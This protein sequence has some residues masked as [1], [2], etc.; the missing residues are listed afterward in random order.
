[1]VIAAVIVLVAG[2]VGTALWLM[3]GTGDQLLRAVPGDADAAVT[4]YLDPSASQKMQLV[5]MLSRFPALG[6]EQAVLDRWNGVLDDALEQAGLTHEDLDWVGSQI[7]AWGDFAGGEPRGGVLLHVDDRAAAEDAMRRLQEDATDGG[8]TVTQRDHEGTEVTVFDGEGAWAIEDDVLF[9]GSD[10]IAVTHAL[11]AMA[12][13]S[14]ALEDAAAFTTATDALPQDRLALFYADVEGLTD[15]IQEMVGSSTPAMPTQSAIQFGVSVSAEAEGLA[16][17]F[18]TV[19]DPTQLDPEVRDAMDADQTNGTLEAVPADAVVVVGATHVDLTIEQALEALPPEAG[20]VQQT[21]EDAGVLGP[22]GL[23]ENLRGDLSL[24]MVPATDLPV[25]GVLA[26]GVDDEA[27]FASFVQD[28]LEAAGLPPEFRD[29]PTEDHGG[30]AVH[31]APRDL[32]APVAWAVTDGTALVG[33]TEGVVGAAEALASGDSIAG[34][35]RYAEAVDLVDA[36]DSLFYADVEG[37]LS[38]VRS[39]MPPD[40]LAEFEDTVAPYLDPIDRVVAGG[41]GDAT[42]QTGRFMILIP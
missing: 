24:A 42:A 22:G 34:D 19:T 1:V 10:E 15:G 31:V 30:V 29:W 40:E 4:I 26:L 37:I 5:R 14:E 12:G 27:A 9:V 18:V 7:V 28:G 32:G 16:M 8:A 11:D 25:G 33:T 23:V 36:S 6:D 21:L 20:D 41:G 13:R 39:A 35:E 38:I 17:D 2:G 3:R